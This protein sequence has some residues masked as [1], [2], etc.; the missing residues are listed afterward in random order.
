MTEHGGLMWVC[1]PSAGPPGADRTG[2]GLVV[3]AARLLIRFLCVVAESRGNEPE[4]LPG[5][6]A[7]H[8]SDAEQDGRAG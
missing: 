2:D 1:A 5:S 6:L 8:W 7:V 4:A 3:A